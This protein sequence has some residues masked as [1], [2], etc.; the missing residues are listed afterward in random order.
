MRLS[1]RAEQMSVIQAVAEENFVRRIAD[2]LLTQYPKA[3][4]RL[5]DDKKSA[6]DE[7]EEETLHSLVRTG[8]ARA[9]GYGLSFESSIA[10]FTAVMFEVA[11]NFD[12]HRLSQVLLNDE[13]V[14]PNHRL[15]ELLNVL[16]EKNWESIRADYD[17]QAWILKEAGG[18]VEE[19][20]ETDQP[21]KAESKPDDLDFQE[22]VKI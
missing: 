15:D 8:I 13:E 5:P 10:A 19:P 1:I 6:V 9:R 20:K 22:T 21:V 18:E 14:D 7:L 4:V 17:P 3:E 11:P 16:T 12:T 2:H